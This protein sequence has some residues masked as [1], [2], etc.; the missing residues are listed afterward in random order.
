MVAGKQSGP[1]GGPFFRGTFVPSFFLYIP[2][3]CEGMKKK[4]LWG[5]FGSLFGLFG[6]LVSASFGIWLSFFGSS[7]WEFFGS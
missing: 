7:L 4:K 1:L 6:F 2:G 3:C 5:F